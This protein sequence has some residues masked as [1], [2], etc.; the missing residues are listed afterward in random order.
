LADSS[1]HEAGKVFCQ[2]GVPPM[3]VKMSMIES[4]ARL[5]A[6]VAVV[7]VVIMMDVGVL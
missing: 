6:Y 4:D 3:A 5:F 2:S 1:E 7:V